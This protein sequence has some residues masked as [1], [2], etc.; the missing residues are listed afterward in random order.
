MPYISTNDPWNSGTA[1]PSQSSSASNQ[2]PDLGGV[3]QQCSNCGK[4]S[5]PL[6]GRDPLT[7]LTLCNVC[8]LYLQ[9]HHEQRP[10]ALFDA[11]DDD[12]GSEGSFGAPEGPECSPC[13]TLQ[14]S[15]WRRNKNGDQVYNAC[16][17]FERLHGTERPLSL[18]K[19]QSPPSKGK[20]IKP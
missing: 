3:I 15:V 8:G 2:E 13:H 7:L 14:T 9:Q 19:K 1:Y 10:Q 11:A 12:E 17:V 5:T 18:K 4:T 16:G 6:W 20:Q